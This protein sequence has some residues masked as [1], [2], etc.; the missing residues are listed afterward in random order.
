MPRKMNHLYSVTVK[1]Y[2]AFKS[3][4]PCTPPYAV[5]KGFNSHRRKAWIEGWL[6]AQREE[7]SK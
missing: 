6:C 2:D 5:S 3:G 7:A 4:N 1:G